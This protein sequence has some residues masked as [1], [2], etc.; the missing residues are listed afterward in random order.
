MLDWTLSW[1]CCALYVHQ[2]LA[3]F[4]GVNPRAGVFRQWVG[5]ENSYGEKVMDLEDTNAALYE[6][7]GGNQ[8]VCANSRV[9][10]FLC[11]G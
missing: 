9:R 10:P 4:G 5:T 6:I 3:D 8:M 11:D 2:S 1:C 7:E